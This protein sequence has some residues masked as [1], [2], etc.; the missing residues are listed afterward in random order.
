M[1]RACVIAGLLAS[2]L[3]AG[4][5][6]GAGEPENFAFGFEAYYSGLLVAKGESILHWSEGRYAVGFKARS[7]G[8]LD[9]FVSF[10]EDA[11][12]VGRIGKGITPERFRSRNKVKDRRMELRF[13]ANEVTI[14]D[15]RPDPA[16]DEDAT[17][18]PAAM[19]VGSLDPL[20]AVLALGVRTGTTGQCNSVVPV[21]DGRRRYDTVLEPRDTVTYNGPLGQA[22][23]LVCNFRFIRRAGYPEEASQWAGV[24]GAVWLQQL[25]EGL[26]MMPV[27]ME[28]ETRYG[29]G[30]VHMISAVRQD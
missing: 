28:V 15:A 3:A 2:V 4:D 13:T 18:V 8:I 27:R 6:A 5:G 12:A 20:S 19:R 11:H 1:A 29:T 25:A 24:T 21:Y 30:Y 14:V 17:P 7:A 23:T 22:S 9:W 10:D 26:P 16:T